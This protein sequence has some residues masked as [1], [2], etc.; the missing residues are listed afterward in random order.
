MS[1]GPQRTC[2]PANPGCVE[3][4][5]SKSRTSLVIEDALVA[6]GF[7]READGVKSAERGNTVGREGPR[8][9]VN[10]LGGLAVLR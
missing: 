1:R 4:F 5:G 7:K 9:D 10:V 6:D 2:M 8:R 3:I